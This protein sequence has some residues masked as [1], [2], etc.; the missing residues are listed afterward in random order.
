MKSIEDLK[1][2]YT[3]GG[4]TLKEQTLTCLNVAMIAL[5]SNV[6]LCCGLT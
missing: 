5:E 4:L 1:G 2:E 6:M 3:R